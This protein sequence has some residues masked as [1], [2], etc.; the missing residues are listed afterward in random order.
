MPGTRVVMMVVP[1]LLAD[2]MRSALARADASLVVE[3][4]ADAD[5]GA[6]LLHRLHADVI[7]LGPAVAPADATT[8]RAALPAAR[9]LS[10]SSDLRWLHGP[11]EPQRQPFN[12]RNLVSAALA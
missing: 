3:E 1:R 9:V 5:T 12:A 6:A 7:I 10:L 8:I 11:A 2:M 4:H